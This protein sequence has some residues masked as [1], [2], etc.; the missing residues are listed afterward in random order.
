MEELLDLAVRHEMG[1]GLCGEV[2]VTGA[3]R[4]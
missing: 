4:P 2:D 3:T 1:H